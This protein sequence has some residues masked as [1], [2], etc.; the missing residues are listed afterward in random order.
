MPFTITIYSGFSLVYGFINIVDK[1]YNIEA[2]EY[3]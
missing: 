1:L 3:K 2:N